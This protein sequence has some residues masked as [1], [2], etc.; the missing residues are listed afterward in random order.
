M[1]IVT[2]HATLLASDNRTGQLTH[3][4]PLSPSDST[5]PID[6]TDAEIAMLERAP[7]TDGKPGVP[8]TDG[9]LSGYLY[10]KSATD[11]NFSLVR[12]GAFV[13]AEPG[14]ETIVCNRQAASVWETFRFIPSDWMDRSLRIGQYITGGGYQEI[15]G[16]T[17]VTNLE[18]LLQ[19]HHRQQ[20]LGIK[21]DLIAIG[22]DHGRLLVLLGLLARH[23]EITVAIDVF[24]F[25]E[26]YDPSGGAATLNNV[27]ENFRS[28]VGALDDSLFTHIA[29]DS[30]LLS[31]EIVKSKLK[32][33]NARIISIDGAHSHFHTVHDMKISGEII[34]PGGIVLV[35]DITNAGWPG[36]MEGVARYLLFSSEQKLIP[37][38]MGDNKLWLTTY[39]YHSRYLDHAWR[40]VTVGPYQHKRITNFFG[41]DIVGF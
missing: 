8:I 33:G 22:V 11:R 27:R 14:S 17:G 31:P 3:V 29:G 16:A 4:G 19:Y 23:D 38:M 30:F 5:T 24:E 9:P 35:D 10:L 39:D 20:Q 13:C 32:F 25:Y 37:F 2:H 6:L 7:P 28:I 18:R 40:E 26:N 34:C 15:P 21:G 12:D 1:Y 36:V 41:N